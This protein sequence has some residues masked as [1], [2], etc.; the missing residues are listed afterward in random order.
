VDDWIRGTDY[1][2]GSQLKTNLEVLSKELET[3]ITLKRR[4]GN[5]MAV[6]NTNRRAQNPI[7]E[8]E[9]LVILTSVVMKN[10]FKQLM[11]AKRSEIQKLSPDELL[12]IQGCLI[13][14]LILDTALRQE[15]IRS[16]TVTE[17]NLATFAK[18]RYTIDI[19]SLQK[20]ITVHGVN[21]FCLNEPTYQALRGYITEFRSH[22]R[23]VARS[24]D[25][26]VPQVFTKIFKNSRDRFERYNHPAQ[27]SSLVYY[28]TVYR[29][30]TQ[31]N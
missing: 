14:R 24:S 8:E 22:L 16:L 6:L 10:S 20:T 25:E 12:N 21:R 9:V 13:I 1:Q 31:V 5:K 11:N 26:L 19:L 3:E 27:V 17:V 2:T 15:A 23:D 4:K 29:L 28:Y 7:T 30:Q 18:G